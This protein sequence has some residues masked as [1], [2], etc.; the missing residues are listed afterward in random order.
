MLYIFFI[1][2]LFYCSFQLQCMEQSTNTLSS[3]SLSKKQMDTLL[4]EAAQLKDLTEIEDF[5]LT[6]LKGNKTLY[7]QRGYTALMWATWNGYTELVKLLLS[8]G[9][10]PN[11]KSKEG[12]WTPLLYAT[13]KGHK[14]IIELLLAHG[15]DVNTQDKS[16]KAA[17]MLVAYKGYKD[18]VELLLAYGADVNTKD[19]NWETAL[20][21]ASLFN[22]KEVVELLINHNAPI[23]S[24]DCYGGT[25]LSKA[26]QNK[27]KEIAAFLI[28][29][30]AD[31][32]ANV[33]DNVAHGFTALDYARIKECKEL[34]HLLELCNDAEVQAYLKDPQGY[35][36]KKQYVTDT[37]TTLMLACAFGH[38]NIIS[39]YKNHPSEYINAQDSNGYTAFDYALHFN[40]RSAATLIHTFGNK[41]DKVKNN[42]QE[43]L[44]DAIEQKDVGLITALLNAGAAPLGI[45]QTQE[46]GFLN[47]LPKDI[48]AYLLLFL[49]STTKPKDKPQ[50]SPE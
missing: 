32:N 40:K 42:K 39:Y 48:F 19:K 27:H 46:A 30:G 3:E 47:I 4:I 35:A 37:V 45:A 2:S 14:D 5:L 9:D 13:Q 49:N 43:L 22:H 6:K 25:A 36:E 7:E 21:Y 10:D 1:F 24:L 33:H 15:A 17:L 8:K 41:I 38:T 44:K 18:I 11:K 34:I 28:S 29:K 26:A 31:A 50:N 20:M 12:A 23:N 16:G